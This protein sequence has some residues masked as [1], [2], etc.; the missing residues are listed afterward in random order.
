MLHGL[1]LRVELRKAERQCLS[2][3]GSG[4]TQ[5]KGAVN[6]AVSHSSDAGDQLAVAPT[7]LG[8]GVQHADPGA[9]REH[10]PDVGPL[11]RGGRQ[12]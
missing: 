10:Q 6:T 7:V 11:H 3:E 5:G 12:R 8:R 2:H 4:G 1:V 9:G